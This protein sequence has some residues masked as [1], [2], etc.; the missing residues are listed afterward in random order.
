[1]PPRLRAALTD[2]TTTTVN[3]NV[4]KLLPKEKAKVNAKVKLTPKI[5][6]ENQWRTHILSFYMYDKSLSSYIKINKVGRDPF[7]TRWEKSGLREL[8]KAK[9][10]Y[11]DAETQ[12]DFWFR[13]WRGIFIKSRQKNR[14]KGHKEGFII[15]VD[16]DDNDDDDDAE[17][18]K[19]NSNNDDD[20][21]SHDDD[22]DDTD[23]TEDND[24]NANKP[25][26][27]P[28]PPPPPL[29][30][31]Q[32]EEK[33][34]PPTKKLNDN[35]MK[36][37]LFEFY[38]R[39]DKMKLLT[40]IKKKERL[41]N[42]MAIIRHWKNSNLQDL[43]F[44]E[45]EVMTAFNSYD[46]WC[47]S[48]KKK[49]GRKN[50]KNGSSGKAIPEVIEIFIR[51]LIKQLALCG[52][53]LGKKAV[54]KIIAE[55][56]RDGSGNSNGSFSRS[57]LNRFFMNYRLECKN[58]KNIDP[59][60]ILQVTPENR[61]AFFFRLDQVVKL[62]NSVDPVNCKATD[63]SEVTADCI[64]NMDELGTDPTK[65]RDVLLVPEEI[66][67]RIF[68][69]TPEGDRPSTHLSFAMFS[70][71]NG[72]YK[73]QS[74]NIE[75]SPMPMMIHSSP[76]KQDGRS[77]IE[78]RLGLYEKEDTILFDEDRFTQGFTEEDKNLGITIRSSTNGSMTKLLFLDAV[79]HYIKNLPSDQGADGKYAF[80]LLDSHV[81]R[82][83][84][85][86][87]YILFK[88][89]IIPIFFP[90]HLSIVVQPQDNGVILFFHK[91]MEEAA[92]IPR[93]FKSEV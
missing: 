82:W 42:K 77:P 87:L 43:K 60:R 9:M 13:K 90:S 2:S 18:G 11:A 52:Q 56:L 4:S 84:P 83:N 6:D 1:M 53:G 49:T 73:D 89:R 86:A 69:A 85:Q 61:D 24:N 40:F 54:R 50:R 36:D 31:E 51:N 62:V 65:F 47:A 8:K 21:G 91:C 32:E 66:L 41:S 20:D 45:V 71:S 25:P 68:Q 92:Q 37:F 38:L 17:E 15:Y 22:D 27:P 14:S 81:S 80:L 75:G 30:E 70:C 23:G 3:K 7:R 34:S 5:D 35:E 55:A 46:S 93:L 33:K 19:S 39:T 12:Y 88:H 29:E 72:K 58:V 48:E 57:T 67:N 28:P 64:Y 79:L 59:A 44:Q 78:R 74:A 26:P 76:E 16:E 63:W 10:P